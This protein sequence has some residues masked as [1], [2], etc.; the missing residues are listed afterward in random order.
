MSSCRPVVYGT[1]H[2]VASGHYLAS[3]AGFQILEAGG[4]AVDAGVAAGIALSV[5]ESELVSFAGVAPIILYC[6]DRDEIVSISGLGTWPRAASADYFRDNHAGK[7][8]PGILRTVVPAAPDAWITALERYGTLGFADVSAAAI[9]YA[10]EGFH[11][12]PLMADLIAKH[13]DDYDAYDSSRAI[14]LPGG[15]V[16]EVGSLFR[17]TDLAA[18]LRYMAEEDRA[19]ARKGGRGAGLEA[20]RHAFYKGDIAERIAAFHRDEQGFLTREDLAGFAV[21][22]EPSVSISFGGA[23]VHGCGAWCQG[24]MLLQALK[25]LEGYDLKELGHNSAAYLHLVVEAVKLAAADRERFYGDPRFVEVPLSR[26][27]SADY[28]A[29]RRKLID[30]DKAWSDLP[31]AGDAMTASATNAGPENTGSAMDTT[32]VCVVDRHGNAFSATPSDASYNAPVVPGLGF[33]ASPR[34][35]QSWTDPS[36]PSSLVPGKRPRLTPNPA[37]ALTRDRIIPFGSPGGDVQTQAMLQALLNLLVFDFDVQAAVEAPRVASYSFPSSFQPHESEPGVLR[38]EA[39]LPDDVAADMQAKGHSVEAWP[40]FTWL[41]G[42]VSMIDAD[43]GPGTRRGGS[44]PRR[45]GYAVGW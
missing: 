4:N 33:V 34:G 8:P 22:V 39:R 41:A 12:Y 13:R 24:P 26:L 31:P 37:L 20:A 43:R 10:A 18:T 7:I 16:P 9:G 3:L 2:V 38:M 32:Y 42:S 29:A 40:G 1:R 19:A 28:A 36:H 5:L 14:Y 45:A 27:L 6:A 30:P 21:G 44:D 11:M 15:K 23:E 35:S 17:Q 25:I